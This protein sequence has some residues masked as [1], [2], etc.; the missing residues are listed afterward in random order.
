MNMQDLTD[1]IS[2]EKENENTPD[3]SLVKEEQVDSEQ[4]ASEQIDRP[5]YLPETY[6]NTEKKQ[7]NIEK[8]TTDLKSSNER[9]EG[10]RK[11]LSTGDQK[12]VEEY[13]SIFEDSELNEEQVAESKVWVDLA[14]K[15]GLS[16]SQA[17]GLL[18][19]LA[20]KTKE[21]N[22]ENVQS[23]EDIISEMG[24]NAL[25]TLKGLEQYAI[26]KVNSGNWTED[27]KSAFAN[28]VYDAKSAKIMAQMLQQGNESV[29]L[30]GLGN[31]TSGFSMDEYYL[32]KE[33]A[34]KMMAT[35]D[36]DG[37]QSLLNEMDIKFKSLNM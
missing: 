20:E 4:V 29:N 1:S 15:N 37:G 8:L 22:S 21:H 13:D 25:Q 9:V 11:K 35:G 27:D 24:E 6:W 2:A 17:E 5:E 33:K 10:L 31:R 7:A 30:A 28:M 18:K 16:K 12:K 19:D 3:E 36:R 34:R 14:R 23:K 26:Q 32:G